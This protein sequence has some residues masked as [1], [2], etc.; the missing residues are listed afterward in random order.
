[1]SPRNGFFLW[2]G[3]DEDGFEVPLVRVVEVEEVEVPK[4]EGVEKVE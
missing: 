3:F 4:V 1:M 2:V